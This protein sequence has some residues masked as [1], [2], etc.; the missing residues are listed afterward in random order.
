MGR[1]PGVLLADRAEGRLGA[2]LP[3]GL[4]VAGGNVRPVGGTTVTE[5]GFLAAPGDVVP[6]GVEGRDV[7]LRWTIGR[8]GQA[9]GAVWPVI[10]VVVKARMSV[11]GAA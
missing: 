5:P 8:S 7:R 3:Q 10:A 11:T 6:D 2:G 1:E 9:V 4:Q